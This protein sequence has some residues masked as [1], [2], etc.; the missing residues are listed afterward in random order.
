MLGKSCTFFSARPHRSVVKPHGCNITC[1]CPLL[2][3]A[4]YHCTR[5]PI[6][7]FHLFLYQGWSMARMWKIEDRT[8]FHFLRKFALSS[9]LAGETGRDFLSGLKVRVRQTA[10]VCTRMQWSCTFHIWGISY[11]CQSRKTVLLAEEKWARW[12]PFFSFFLL[13]AMTQEGSCGFWKKF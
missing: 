13:R 3:L 6:Y 12:P 1:R 7:L 9:W 10:P 2:P 5:A 8:F 4:Y 11:P